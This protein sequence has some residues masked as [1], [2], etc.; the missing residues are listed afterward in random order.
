MILS[1]GNFFF[2]IFSSL[3]SIILFPYLSLYIPSL[4]IGF[5]IAGSAIAG[6]LVFPFLPEVVE[7]YGPQKIALVLSLIEIVVLFGL[8]A[9]PG[10]IGAVIL[11]AVTIAMQPFLAYQFDLLVEATVAD[12]NTTGQVRAIFRTAWSSAAL[13]A[14]LL[15][16][17]LLATS[18]SYSRVFLAA[19]A[20]LVPIIMLFVLRELPQGPPPM[21]EH[22]HNT[23]V[24]IVKNK[25]LA[26]VTLGNLILYLFLA[27]MPLYV[28]FYLHNI[29]HFPWSDLG[30]IFALMLI[31]YVVIEYPAG[32]IADK[33]LG[34][35]E[36][37]YMGYFIAGAS[38][39]AVSLITPATSLITILIILVSSRIGAALIESMVE[40]HFF[41]RIN[42]RDI[43]TIGA[44]RSVWP[45]S[46]IIG[47]MVAS[48]ILILTNYPT[49][50]F[51]IGIFIAGAGIV[52]TFFITDFQ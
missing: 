45:L 19:A 51:L 8:A 3:V 43:N 31:P 11:M 16:G 26:A 46:Y 33:Y 32:W 36:L 39:A 20:T 6:I 48:S 25:D 42:H 35:K 40:A 18:D 47:P 37:M 28:P 29:L 30:W 22:M 23:L 4:S 27:W 49:F 10:P 38:T 21:L 50:F 52:T 41:R 17:A 34:D 1:V 7:Q 15:L 24:R 14:P 44:F 2:S 12:T 5:V 9:A 13:A